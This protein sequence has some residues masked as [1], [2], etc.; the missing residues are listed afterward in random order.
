M[1]TLDEKLNLVIPVQRDGGG[2]IYIHSA[3]LSRSVFEAHY[4]VIGKTFAA[5]TVEGLSMVAGP[6]LMEPM[7]RDI[8]QQIGKWEGPNGVQRALLP[9]IERLTSVLRP[10]G[11]GEG[12]QQVPLHNAL[13]DGVLTDDERAEVMGAVLFF[14]VTSAMQPRRL[15]PAFLEGVCDLWGTRVTS[16][17]ATAFAASL[18]TSTGA[19]STGGT[20]AASSVPS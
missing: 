15:L 19:A 2:T 20:A 17:N 13:K 1:A 7:L 5:L 3:P 18:P 16:Q 8:A 10:G 14:M 12:W 6:Q 9:E 11:P 4:L